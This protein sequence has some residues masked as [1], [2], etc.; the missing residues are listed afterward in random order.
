[1]RLFRSADPRH[2]PA[3]CARFGRPDPVRRALETLRSRVAGP[4]DL[5]RLA[6]ECGV[7]PHHPSRRVRRETGATLQRHLRRPRVE[8]AC[9]P[10]AGGRTNVTKIALEVGYQ[11]LSHFAKAFREELGRTPHEWL[12]AGRRRSD[13]GGG[14]F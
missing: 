13:T 8:R 7:A 9:D 1:V 2:P 12:A 3:F 4:L 5:K 14:E 6:R 11:S 10:L